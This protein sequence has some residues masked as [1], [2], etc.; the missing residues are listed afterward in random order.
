M[1]IYVRLFCLCLAV[2]LALLGGCK[3]KT[4]MAANGPALPKLAAHKP[5]FN[6]LR[7]VPVGEFPKS[8]LEN[9]AGFYRDRLGLQ[10]EVT[11]T[12]P[13]T[14]NNSITKGSQIRADSITASASWAAVKLPYDRD[15]ITIGVTSRD[16]W[17]DLTQRRKAAK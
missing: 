4:A 9:L 6:H 16:M 12:A 8:T 10:V 14:A 5:I 15:A 17:K 11:D 2:S 7:L 1:H 3:S 13:L